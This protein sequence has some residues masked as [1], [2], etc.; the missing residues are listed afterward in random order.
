[1]GLVTSVCK[2]RSDWLEF[3]WESAGLV[4]SVRAQGG[5]PDSFGIGQESLPGQ[6]GLVKIPLGMGGIG[7][8]SLQEQ[9][10]LV[11]IPLGVCRLVNSVSRNKQ[12]WLKS[13]WEWDSL[14]KSVCR[15]RR[16]FS[17]LVLD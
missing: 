1:M 15:S 2:S 11:R 3:F 10:G 4:V 6:V 16:N 5:D 14:V 9:E 12:D 13:C 7:Q 17:E 8:E